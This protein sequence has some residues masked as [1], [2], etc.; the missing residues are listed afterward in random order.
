MVAA[1]IVLPIKDRFQLRQVWLQLSNEI[2]H[3]WQH[4]AAV[5]VTGLESVYKCHHLQ[6][7]VLC[8][9]SNYSIVPGHASLANQSLWLSLNFL[10]RNFMAQSCTRSTELSSRALIT[11]SGASSWLTHRSRCAFHAKMFCLAWPSIKANSSQERRVHQSKQTRATHN[12]RR[13]LDDHVTGH[14]II[15]FLWIT[16]G[17]CS[18]MVWNAGLLRNLHLH[19]QYQVAINNHLLFT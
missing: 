16:Q 14:L 18:A 17:V 7:F 2:F 10:G 4:R 9:T 11:S 3:N 15:L 8:P 13:F 6:I 1:S 12:D 5:L 19:R